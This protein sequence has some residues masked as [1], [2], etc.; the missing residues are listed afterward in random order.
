MKLDLASPL[1]FQERSQPPVTR[2]AGW[3][4]LVQTLGISAPVCHPSCV[5]QQH[6]SGSRREEGGWTVLDKR[7]WP[8]ENFA[9]HLL[10]AL[11]HEDLDLLILKRVFDAVP[12]AELQALVRGEP[13]SM[14]VRRAWYLYELLTGRTIDADDA[15]TIA[16][17]DLLDP[18]AYFIGK[19]RVS[20]RHRVRDNLLGTARFCPVIRRTRNL[21]DAVALD[22]AAKARGTVGRTGAHLVARAAS[23]LLLA[24]SRASFQIEG[25]RPPRNRLERWGRAVLQAGKIP[26]TLN[27]I[28]RLQSVLIEDTRFVRAGLRPDGVFLGERDHHGD[29]LPE[30]IG[31]RPQDLA[32]LMSGLFEANDRMRE[33]SIDPVLKAAA[34]AFGFVYIHPFEDG[35]GRMHRCLIHH[36]LAERKFTPPGMVFPVSSVMLDRI[37]DYR[38]TLQGHSGPLMPFI[39]W[40]PTLSRNVEVLNDTA[41]LYRYFDCTEEAEFLYACVRRTVESD[42]PREIDYLRRHDEAIHRIM[43][44]V[45]MPDRVAEDLVMFIRQNDG[46]LSENRREHEFKA[47]RDDEVALIEGIVRDAFEGFGVKSEPRA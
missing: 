34:T 44:A 4:A 26:L 41:D 22:L 3:S 11:R 28:L 27:E 2:L 47:L 38:S 20:R 10:F 39:E 30:F 23:F 32:D 40:H 35:N 37:D 1:A 42:L 33:D 46:S 31:A 5:S 17:V 25:E 6:V 43:H 21:E 29:P 7:Y 19:P 24:D 13:T 36:V 45:E 15:P 14:P 12:P 18:K 16:A 8:G 9:D